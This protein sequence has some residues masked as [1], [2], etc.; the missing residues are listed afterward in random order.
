MG[1]DMYAFK[2]HKDNVASGTDEDGAKIV[3]IIDSDECVELKYWRKFN[4][5]HGFFENY[6]RE[7]L[8]NDGEF[9][10]VPVEIDEDVLQLLEQAVKDKALV[11]VTGF[12]FGSQEALDEDDYEDVS[13]FIAKVREVHKKEPDYIVLYDSW[14]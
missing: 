14:W 3:E 12:F 5:L 8:G 4:A 10:C 13:D 9:N 11:P 6:W 2:T 1:L 7:V